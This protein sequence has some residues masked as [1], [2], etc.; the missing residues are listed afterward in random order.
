MQKISLQKTLVIFILCKPIFVCISGLIGISNFAFVFSALC[1]AIFGIIKIRIIKKKLMIISFITIFIMLILST[2]IIRI[3]EYIYNVAYSLLLLLTIIIWI[4]G[5]KTK[6]SVYW[7]YSLLFYLLLCIAENYFFGNLTFYEGRATLIGYANPL[8]AARDLAVTAAF[9]FLVQGQRI[10]IT[11]VIIFCSILGFLEA[12]GCAI[13]LLLFV[14]YYV[15]FR[16]ILLALVM[17]PL[18][19]AVTW[20]LNPFSAMMRVTEW[21][22]IVRN[23]HEIP[24]L[25]YGLINY[26]DIPFTQL[27]VYSHNWVLDYILAK[28][29]I[30][31][32]LAIFAI[33]GLFIGMYLKSQQNL[34]PI[35][36]VPLM[37]GLVGLTQ[38]SLIGSLLAVVLLPVLKELNT[39]NHSVNKLVKI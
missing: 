23:I 22:M 21:Y 36:C 30:G 3:E 31:L 32:V 17:V 15:N 7:Q 33:R 9:I 13:V 27:G 16:N 11:F 14:A 2:E 39:I 8:W 20:S 38:G 28:G 12:R 25:G 1:I 29:V 26:K 24:I 34:L 35:L 10:N 6:L 4:H 18:L 5:K 19:V 37:Y